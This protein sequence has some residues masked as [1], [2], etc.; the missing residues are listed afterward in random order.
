[1][2]S[3]VDNNVNKLTS[4]FHEYI[5][6]YEYISTTLRGID[7]S[8]ACSVMARERFFMCVSKSGSR[9]E[10]MDPSEAHPELMDPA[11]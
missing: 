4:R 10:S 7:Y 3:T 6:S 11:G 2:P 9:R 8:R 5:T 1:M